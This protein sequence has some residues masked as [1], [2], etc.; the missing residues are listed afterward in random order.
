MPTQR[1]LI[2]SKIDDANSVSMGTSKQFVSCEVL[3]DSTNPRDSKS[4][5]FRKLAYGG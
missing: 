2:N 3:Y 5:I 1:E 4:E